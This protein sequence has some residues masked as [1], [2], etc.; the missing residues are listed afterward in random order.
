MVSRIQLG[1][2]FNSGGK[3]VLG[4]VG[5]SGL[6]TEALVTA[7]SDAKRLQAVKLEDRVKV[8]SEKTKAL[9]ELQKLL[10]A[11]KDSTNFLRNPPGVGNAADNVFK[12]TTST[13]TSNTA[14]AG[15]T[16][17]AVSAAPGASVQNYIVKNITSLARAKIQS[18]GDITIATADTAVVSATP[19][20]GQFG[21][22]TFTLNGEDITFAVGDSLNI[23]AA[24]INA[25]AA[26]TG[27]RA[28]VVQIE[29]GKYQLSFVATANGED[30]DF[31]FNNVDVPGT[32]TDP[33]NVF[34]QITITDKQSAS[35][36]VFELNGTSI[37]RQSN[38]FSDVVS[39]VTFNLLQTTPSSATEL[40][41]EI[42][43]DT[44]IV[45]NG[46]INFVNAYNNLRVFASQQ[47]KLNPDGTFAEDAVLAG[48]ATLRSALN[49]ANAQVSSITSRLIS[50]TPP[51]PAI[52]FADLPETEDAP[53]VR[54]IL[55][56]DEGALDAIIASDPEEVR[57]A[58]EFT[59]A[60]SNPSLRIFSRTN[61]L[62]TEAMTLTVNPFATQTTGIISVADADT[63]VTSITPVNGMFQ[64]GVI[65][66]NG[67][68]I[69]FADGD[70]LNTIAG[71]FNAVSADSGLSA[72]VVTVAS[73]QYRLQFTATP[74]TGGA[75]NFDLSSSV[76]DPDDVFELMT[77]NVTSSYTATYNNGSGPVT[78]NLTGTPLR[79]VNGN[80]TGVTLKGQAG[81]VLEGLV[82]VYAG[83]A[84]DTMD[85]TMEQGIGD[86][87]Y[88][89]M[90]DLLN[91]S[92]GSLE[93]ELDSIKT[94]DTKLNEDIARIDAQVERF[95]QELLDKFAALERAI[96]RVNTLLDSIDAN[97]QAR[98]NA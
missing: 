95:R 69:T 68:T 13:V 40:T 39:G 51:K 23:V 82:L 61:A 81:T 77:I 35:N 34:D 93:V 55:N 75:N 24:K 45:K 21:A 59:F 64:P 96:S 92:T 26:D 18:T 63:S 12:Y 27:I 50:G 79:D 32:L 10:S 54:N 56:V 83:L 94:T 31:D 76:L 16:Y 33:D 14:V 7:L 60:S 17:L 3:T 86:K 71:K 30:A 98:N 2:F 20:A 90:N 52:T 62:N 4:G 80:L 88:N 28:N 37:T 6:D 72:S 43:P 57:S 67:Q 46:V 42:K 84:T 73:G 5:G 78:V 74:V 36:A 15:S 58:F 9:G 8:N 29:S 47:T 66:V 44:Q 87:L 49:L 91:T 1:N 53:E 11:L 22:G 65:T 19:A 48:S 85:V 97:N 38:S 25:V 89:V 70:S 41:V